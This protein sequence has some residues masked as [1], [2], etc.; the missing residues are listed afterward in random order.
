MLVS[1]RVGRIVTT[2]RRRLERYGSR[3]GWWPM[4]TQSTFD[5]L[6]RSVGGANPNALIR[7]L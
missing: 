4:D 6:S 7:I 1:G 3:A 2:I 5:L